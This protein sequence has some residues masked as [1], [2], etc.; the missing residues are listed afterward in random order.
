MAHA[1]REHARERIAKTQGTKFKQ[2]LALLM[3]KLD[4]IALMLTGAKPDVSGEEV[5]DESRQ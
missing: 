1:L 4:A 5:G 3:E 2:Q